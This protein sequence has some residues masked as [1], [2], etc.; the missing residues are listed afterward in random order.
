MK[1]L[2]TGSGLSFHSP[3]HKNCDIVRA[4]RKSLVMDATFLRPLIE[5]NQ[6]TCKYA[7]GEVSEANQSWRLNPETAS[8]GFILRHT[9]EIMHLLMSLMGEP[10][11]VKNT[12]MGF[13]DQGQGAEVSASRN[14]VHSGYEKLYLLADQKDAA[15]WDEVVDT[16]FFG[17]IQRIRLFGHVLNHN[18]YHAG[19]IG[20]TLKRHQAK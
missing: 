16:S 12:T 3:K 5:Q 11:E 2:G 17:P 9:G 7:F 13:E 14:L 1:D 10:T 6:R 20:L 8:A 19:Q 18:A 15:W 4:T